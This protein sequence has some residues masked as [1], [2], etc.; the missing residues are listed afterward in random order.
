M[1]LSP[2]SGYAP[3]DSLAVSEMQAVTVQ[4]SGELLEIRRV[5]PESVRR[6]NKLMG[7]RFGA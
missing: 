6:F 1:H 3:E 5:K 7:I 2:S 4:P